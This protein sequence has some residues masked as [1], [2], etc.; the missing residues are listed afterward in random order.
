[1]S[2]RAWRC[3]AR[4]GDRTHPEALIA[5]GRSKATFSAFLAGC[6]L[7][8]RDCAVSDLIGRRVAQRSSKRESCPRSISKV[9]TLDAPA[10]RVRRATRSR[11]ASRLTIRL[12]REPITKPRE[13]KGCD[14]TGQRALAC[15]M[16]CPRP[17]VARWGL[18]FCAH[19][20]AAI[21][22]YAALM[23][24]VVSVVTGV[25]LH[26]TCNMCMHVACKQ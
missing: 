21:R 14:A 25:W 18:P 4:R 12:S 7:K 24:P 15:V 11:F 5:L 22:R 23:R 13:R 6:T 3:G 9:S 1:M 2:L 17:H 26:T 16:R 10:A 20:R 19:T 8:H